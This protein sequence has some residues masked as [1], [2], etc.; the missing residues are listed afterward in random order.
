M[1]AL[2]GLLWAVFIVALAALALW[3]LGLSDVVRDGV[4]AGRLLDWVMGAVCLFWLIVILKVPWDLYFEAQAVVFEIERGRERGVAVPE[5]REAYVR[6]L[7]RRLGWG[8]VAA[9][10]LSAAFVAAIAWFSG[11]AVGYYFAVFYLAST[12]LRPAMAGYVYLSEKLRAIGQESRYPR[13]DV[14]EMRSRLDG[15]EARIESLEKFREQLREDLAE[16]RSA[17]DEELQ[18]LRQ[19][20]Q[21]LGRHFE[22]AIGQLTDNQEVINGIQAFVRLVAQ[23]T[24][25]AR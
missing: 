9:H 17:I 2:T 21:A 4:A 16:E 10:V 23:S 20:V 1:R 13:E 24:R 25:T 5:G 6:T 12:I 18:Q 15:V 8:A 19:G 3:L 22:S 14:V 11:G 7:R